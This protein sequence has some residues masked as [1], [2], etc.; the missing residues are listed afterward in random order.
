VPR[1]RELGRP[2]GKSSMEARQREAGDGAE[3]GEEDVSV[4]TQ[5]GAERDVDR[6]DEGAW[7]PGPGA[8]AE[9]CRCNG[10]TSI[11]C[12]VATGDAADEAAGVGAEE[13][14]A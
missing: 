3:G 2:A 1:S 11:G 12:G 7:E 14:G 9:A 13:T 8:P 10:G 4:K 5:S 6:G